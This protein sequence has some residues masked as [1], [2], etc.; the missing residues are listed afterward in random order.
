M[1]NPTTAILECAGYAEPVYLSP[2][3]YAQ[4]LM[5]SDILRG[6]DQEVV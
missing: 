1:E 2:V 3:R 4:G 6:T 5:T